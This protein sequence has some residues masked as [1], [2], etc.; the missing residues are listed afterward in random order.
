MAQID[1]IKEVPL[2]IVSCSE[3]TQLTSNVGA[4]GKTTESTSNVGAGGKTTQLTSKARTAK[5]NF[6]YGNI[7]HAVNC[8][9]TFNMLGVLSIPPVSNTARRVDKKPQNNAPR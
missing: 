9:Y 2:K 6:P 5:E 4:G 8:Q 3:S 1:L 7:F